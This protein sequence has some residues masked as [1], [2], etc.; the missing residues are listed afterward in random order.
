MAP[1]DVA[2][3]DPTFVEVRPGSFNQVQFGKNSSIS[4]GTGQLNGDSVVAIMSRYAIFLAH[5]RVEDSPD[6]ILAEAAEWR[7]IQEEEHERH[8]PGDYKKDFP[9]GLFHDI[10]GLPSV[11]VSERIHSDGVPSTLVN[12]QRS[13]I[14]FESMRNLLP[15]NASPILD[16][17]YYVEDRT[18]ASAATVLIQPDGRDTNVFIRDEHVKVSHG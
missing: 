11:L 8:Y 5:I 14:V 18:E 2:R 13:R 17:T 7:K 3:A 9:H 4:I 6:R 1:I 15:G 12:Y 10:H 16:L